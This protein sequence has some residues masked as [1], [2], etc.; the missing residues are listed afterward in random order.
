MKYLLALA[1]LALAPSALLHSEENAVLSDALREQGFS[2]V[3]LKVDGVDREA[4]VYAPK[5]A[6]T[7]P[8]PVVFVFHAHGGSS[9]QVT[10]SIPM[11]RE[12]PEAISVYMQGLNTPGVATDQEGEKH[13]WQ[14]GI[15]D[16]NGRDLKFFDAMLARLKETY[17]VDEKRIFATG[18]SNGGGFTYLLWETRPDVFAAFAVASTATKHAPRLKPKPVL[19]VA[20]EKDPIVKFEAQ[21]RTMEALK[22]NNG[23]NEEG[24]PW[25]DESTIYASKSGPPVVTFFHPGGHEFPAGAAA[26]IARFFKETP[27]REIPAV[28]KS[29]AEKPGADKP[30]VDKSGGD[31]SAEKPSARK[32]DFEKPASK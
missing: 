16:Q 3:A 27:P 9:E 8:T 22:K 4:L 30:G 10:R 29:S 14:H 6:A 1:V 2:H 12:W 19:I 31:S 28:E 7:T 26:K 24:K 20:G 18:H 17:Q 15:E 23:C 25:D 11:F 5:S 21:K 13:G 32:P